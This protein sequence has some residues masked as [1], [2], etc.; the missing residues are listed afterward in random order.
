MYLGGAGEGV[1]IIKIHTQRWGNTFY[2]T[3][4][5]CLCVCVCVYVHMCTCVFVSVSMS[6]C[7]HCYGVG[8]EVRRQLG[9][10]HFY[11]STMWAPWT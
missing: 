9:E 1:N 8:M 7:V 5:V 3:F 11:P 2:F 6:V 10:S 4:F